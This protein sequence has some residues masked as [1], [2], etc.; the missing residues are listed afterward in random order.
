MKN[1]FYE[2]GC[3]MNFFGIFQCI[4]VFLKWFNEM[5]WN[6]KIKIRMNDAG[7]YEE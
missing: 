6:E 4:K 2:W 7:G 1:Y 5:L 3:M